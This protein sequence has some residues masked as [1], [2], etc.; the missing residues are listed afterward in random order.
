MVPLSHA[1]AAEAAPAAVAPAVEAP[2]EAL[3]VAEGLDPLFWDAAQLVVDAGRASVMSI[4]NNLSI[5]H[6]RAQRIM[7]M[8]EAKGIVG[9]ANGR[10]PRTVLVDAAALDALK[11]AL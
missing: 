10:R 9:P 6:S 3:A 11:G 7:D 4:Q 5:G 8:L 2:I 1:P